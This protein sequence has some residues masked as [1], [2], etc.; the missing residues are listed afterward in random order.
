[1]VQQ[2]FKSRQPDSRTLALNLKAV[3]KDGGVEVL[4]YMRDGVGR[5]AIISKLPPASSYPPKSSL[6][7]SN[8]V[9]LLM[10]LFGVRRMERNLKAEPIE[11]GN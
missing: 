11:F 8:S 10:T 7:Q 4:G 5:K 3:L 2:R 6:R 1:M 9:G